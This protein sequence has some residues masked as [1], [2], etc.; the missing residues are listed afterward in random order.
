MTDLHLVQSGFLLPIL[1]GVKKSGGNIKKIKR[2]SGLDKFTI[3][4]TE[5]YIP[6]NT[7]Y[8]FFHQLK[9]I[10]GLTNPHLEF[11]DDIQL[12]S[13]SDWGEMVTFA[14]DLISAIKYAIKFQGIALTNER[15]SVVI[16]G[17]KTSF[18]Q[19]F[20]DIFHEGKTEV[21]YVNLMIILSGF[22]FALGDS[23]DPLEVHIQSRQE[24]DLSGV[25]QYG[26]KTIVKYGQNSTSV[27]FP[28]ELLSA[29]MNNAHD[30]RPLEAPSSFASKIEELIESSSYKPNIQ[31]IALMSD[32]TLRT[33]QRQLAGEDSSFSKILDNWRFKKAIGLLSNNQ[34][35]IKEISERL[36]Y[37]DTSN[38]ERAFRRWV[39][40]SP[41]KYREE[42][43]A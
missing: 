33:F 11:Q 9:A 23:W 22:R 14:P 1:D 2:L 34:L 15:L 7:L 43:L 38:F 29:S 19:K 31:S 18:N 27:V 36:Y 21:D 32:L 37:G 40:K 16:S 30:L 28:T 17:A 35:R 20:T 4:S 42:S 41:G 3:E 24:L 25:L 5:N 39:N 10:E 6:V 13:L 12:S 8:S 26:S